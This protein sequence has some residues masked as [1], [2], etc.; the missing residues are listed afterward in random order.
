MG[1]LIIEVQV[2][3]DGYMAAKNGKTDWMLWNWSNEWNWDEKLRKYHN[4][5]TESVDFIL[6]SRKMA[7]EGF[8]HHW[9]NMAGNHKNSQSGFAKK[10]SDTK[11]VVFTKTLKKSVWENT[12]LAK[13][14]LTK[15][16]NS[17][18]DKTS[19]NIIAYG[20]ATFAT[21]LLKAG[22]V[23]ELHLLINPSTLGRGLSLFSSFKIPLNFSLIS[24]NPYSCGIVVSRYRPH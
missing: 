2:S 8:I 15:E 7:E 18:K 23:D 21:S 1:K 14:D 10:I 9:A 16:V 19:N 11:K 13:G 24:S 3:I 20:G 6:L 12:V 5:L 22:V 17:L 4:D